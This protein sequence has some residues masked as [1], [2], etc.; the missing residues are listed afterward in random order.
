MSA[1]APHAEIVVGVLLPPEWLGKDF[2]G[3]ITSIEAIDPRVRVV[4]ETYVESHD[5]RSA[6]G[7]PDGTDMRDEVPPQKELARREI[8]TDRRR[9]ELRLAR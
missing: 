4:A 8:E 7:R 5:L 9:R 2:A 1:D 6:R 3:A